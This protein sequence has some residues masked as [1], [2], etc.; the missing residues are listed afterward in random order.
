MARRVEAGGRLID[1]ARPVTFRFDGRRMKGFAGDTLASALLASGR[2]VMGRSFKYHRPRGPVAAGAEEPNALVSV[3]TGARRTPNLRATVVPLAEGL[4]AESQNRWPSLDL[5]VGEVNALAY[6]WFP[7]GFY[8]KTFMRPRALWKHLFEPAIR[9][10]AGLGRAP[11]RPDPDDY[12]HYHHETEVVVAG[13]GVS[14][15]AAALAASRGGARVLLVERAGWW[16]GRAPTDGAEI[17]GRPAEA[18][19]RGAVAELRAS[20]RVT[21]RLNAELASVQDH[22]FCLVIEDAAANGAEGGLRERLWKVRAGRVVTATGAIERP[23][24]FAGND[25]PGVMLASAVRDHLDLWGVAVGRRA[26]VATVCDDGY[27]TALALKGAGSAV[28]V[29]DARDAAGPLRAEAEGAGVSVVAGAAVWDVLGRMR[30]K[31]VRVGA[32]DGSGEA[33]EIRCDAVAMAG[34][35]SPVVHLFSQAGGRLVWDDEGAMFRPDAA[36]AARGADG[37]AFVIA[38]GTANGELRAGAALADAHGA[39]VLAAQE[40]LRKPCAASAA[41]SAP[42]GVDAE[43]AA[44]RP[45]W[46]SP[47][48]MGPEAASHAFVDFQNDVKVADVRLAAQEGYES[49]E[50]AKRYT[51]LGMATDQG[52]LSNVVGLAILAEARGAEIPQ[53]GTTTF[54]PPYTPLT[55]GA[56]AGANR[57]ELFKP[58]RRT[59]MDAWHDANGADWEPVGDWRRPFC[60]RRGEE[61]RAQ[62]VEREILAT[63]GGVGMLDASTLGKMLVT[64]PDAGLFLDRVYTNMMSTLKPGRCR[65]GLMCDEGGFLFDDG[66]VARLSEEAFLLHTTSGGAG[67]VHGWLEEWLQTEWWDLRVWV[68]DVTEQWAQVA[69]V[70]PKAREVLERLGGMDLGREALPFMGMAEGTLGGMPARVYRISFSGELSYEVAAPASRGQAL[71][72][73]LREA[74]AEFGIT[75]YGTEALHV[76]RAEKGFVMIGDETDGTVT[77]LDLGLGWAVSKKKDD[78]LGKRGMMRSDLVRDDR[79]RLVGLE[80][81]DPEVVLPDGAHAVEGRGRARRTIGHVTSTYRSPTLGRSI[82]MALIERGPERMGETLRFPVKGGVVKARVVAPGWYDPEGA[83]QD[84]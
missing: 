24:A 75:P 37:E 61:T 10:A 79:L 58:V 42:V 38:A 17:D 33:R 50:H 47:E 76:M 51:T 77:P 19:V 52:K 11:E 13:G 40:V 29:V 20:P 5:D 45:L 26:V 66:V 23:I 62:A 35:W 1:R 81:V 25:R 44:L 78:F 16:G 22:G 84:V 43:E 32:V 18:W 6:R 74:G 68:A 80:T 2:V 3:G 60:Y 36:R 67:R 82:A 71:W 70:G 4:V 59:P 69:V 14:G 28:T 21:M 49:V 53:V 73:A 31:G 7:A 54:R 63:R 41:G 12:E 64:G 55:L 65:Y 39:G 72:H 30:V 15:L 48:G 9:R 27:R 8:Y 46:T 56:I 34:G 83:R 57:R